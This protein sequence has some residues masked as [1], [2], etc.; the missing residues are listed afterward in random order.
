M[1]DG[2][3]WNPAV[4]EVERAPGQLVIS[5]CEP[6]VMRTPHW[7]TQ[8]EVNYVF[9]GT[10]DYEMDGYALRL[11]PGDLVLFWGGQPHRL[12]TVA[13]GSFFHAIHLLL[14]DFF[15]LRLPSA[16]MARIMGGATL[17][18]RARQAEDDCGFRRRGEW[19]ASGRAHLIAHAVEELLLRL[20]RFG[21]EPHETH[22]APSA[23]PL[24]D[25]GREGSHLVERLCA[26]ITENFRE[27]IQCATIA[28]HADVH[29]KY[30]MAAFKRSTGMSLLEYLTLLRVSYAQALLSEDRH[31]I[32]Q[33]AMDSGFGSV[34]AFNKCFRKRAGMNPSE[35]KRRQRGHQPA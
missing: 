25:Q 12:A 34:S 30:A 35:F 21:F 22:T 5:R 14:F 26:Y 9:R 13:P 23:A 15:R 8:V 28:A 27:D 31:S 4:S 10:L 7:H 20:G 17:V 11:V 18:A 3:Y 19:M 24:P 16:T 32:L 2:T 1:N 33:V 29:P 6:K